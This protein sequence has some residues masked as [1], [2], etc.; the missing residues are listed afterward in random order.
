METFAFQSMTFSQRLLGHLK[1]VCKHKLYVAQ[2]CFKCGLYYQGI[3]HDLS[4]FYPSEFFVGVRY[5]DGHKSPNAVQRRINEGCSTAWLH[6]KGRNRHHFEYWI[7]YAA[8]NNRTVY[9]NRM[10]MRYVV[11]MVCDRRAACIAYQGRD[12]SPASPWEHYLISRRHL[13]MNDDTRCVLEKCLKL[14]MDEG[15][16]ACFKYMRSLLDITKGRDYSAELL[17]LPKSEVEVIY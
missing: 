15:E 12:Y 14:M 8:F 4:K 7:D 9:G 13:I 5:Y 6:H 10:P 17:G 11:E 3:T 16:D 1:T 2:G